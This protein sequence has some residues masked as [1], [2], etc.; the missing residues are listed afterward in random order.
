MHILSLIRSF[1]RSVKINYS[2]DIN[3]DIYHLIFFKTSFDFNV[4]SDD[5][6]FGS[7]IG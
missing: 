4:S 3:I 5:L 1:Y 7:Q 6:N 2:L